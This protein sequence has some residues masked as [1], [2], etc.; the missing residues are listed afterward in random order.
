MRALALLS[1]FFALA[2]AGC[3]SDRDEAVG[4]DSGTTAQSD[5]SG[6]VE[7]DG[8]STVGPYA[9]AAAERFQQANPDVRVTVGV[10]GTGGGF[11]RF[12]AGETD[13]SNASRPIDDDEKAI[14]E[15]N[16]VEY[17]EFHIANDALTVVANTEND[18]ATCLTVE[19]LKQIWDQGSRVKNWNQVDPEFPDQPLKL[20]GPGTDS[21]TFDY[22]TAEINGEE[23]QSRSDYS[24]TED[25]N[26]I[27]Q[28]VSG[29]TGALGYFGLSYFTENEGTLKA[30]EVDGGNGCVAP[31][32]ETAQNGEYTPLSR[33]LFIY[34]KTESLARPE[35]GAF[36]GFILD[37][38]TEI[39][40]AAQFVPLT[41]EQ[42]EKARSDFE[43]A[44]G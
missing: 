9:T 3:G 23:G 11:E 1:L 36:I 20:Y 6:T 14:C 30:L 41:D 15:Q 12:C 40:E 37:N 26:V 39:A 42:L 31:S 8:S 16:G 27:V 7:A 4:D 29:D 10:S 13:L 21:G 17:V 43:G 2:L 19:Q 32:V 5:L 38:E 22:F 35:V 25:D 34:A 44:T 18:W 33:P 28:G 24:A